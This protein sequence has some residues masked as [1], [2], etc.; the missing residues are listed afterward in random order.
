ML[1]K[2]LLLC[3]VLTVAITIYPLD[4]LPATYREISAISF[5]F[6]MFLIYLRSIISTGKIKVK[7]GYKIYSDLG[8]LEENLCVQVINEND[9]PII[10]EEIGFVSWFSKTVYEFTNIRVVRNTKSINLNGNQTIDAHSDER[11]FIY[12][13]GLDFVHTRPIKRVYVKTRDEKNIYGKNKD[14]NL[15]IEFIKSI[16]SKGIGLFFYKLFSHTLVL[17]FVVIGIVLFFLFNKIYYQ[18]KKVQPPKPQMIQSQKNSKLEDKISELEDLKKRCVKLLDMCADKNG[19]QKPTVYKGEVD[20]WYDDVDDFLNSDL[21]RH[22]N[23]FKHWR[24]NGDI[25]LGGVGFYEL[26]LWNK[27]PLTPTPNGVLSESDFA[28]L[29][30]KLWNIRYYLSEM[31]RRDKGLPPQCP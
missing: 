25:Y 27:R 14:F 9:F 3:A 24:G 20:E 16:G 5:V 11:F 18:T 30:R 10:I 6:V 13:G 26:D 31:K 29:Q 4:N 15:R 23:E 28:T 2:I 7:P 22:D 19:D 12:N 21:I 1:N 17:I 8:T